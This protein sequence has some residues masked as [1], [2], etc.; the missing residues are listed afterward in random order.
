[1]YRYGR[2]IRFLSSMSMVNKTK[3]DPIVSLELNH[4]TLV[5]LEK[6]SSIDHFRQILGQMMRIGLVGETF[7][8]SRL[9][10]YSAVSHPENLDMAIL[11]FTY[12]TPH[13]NLFIYKTMISAL[14]SSS[15]LAY[16]VYKSMLWS[17]IWPEKQ[18]LLYL[19]KAAKHISEAKQ[20]HCHA[21]V[22]GL[23]SYDYF[24]NSLLKM[25]VKNGKMDLALKVFLC[26]PNS[27]VASFNIM[28]DDRAKKGKSLE[29]LKMYHEM[30]G[31]GLEPDEFTILD[32]L[33]CCGQ[34]ADVRLGK[35]V[36]AWME[37]RK[38]ISPSN[39]VLGNALLH[40]YVKCKEI[41]LAR[42]TFDALRVKDIVSWNTMLEGFAN[43]GELESARNL[44]NLMPYRDIVSWNS[45][46]CSYAQNDDLM[47]M[48]KLFKDMVAENVMPD[49]VT[50][51]IVVTV[52][53]EVGA[54]D[55]G[56]WIHGMVVR[57][58]MKINAILGSALIN[59]YWKCGNVERAFMVFRELTEKDVIVWTT[60]ITGFA[61]HGYGRKAL[62]LFSEM[63]EEVMPNKVT[64]LAVL[65]ACVHCGLVDE[66]L[67]IFSSMKGNYG[68][69]PGIEH[70]G[71][72]VDLLG[73]SGRLT[74]AKDV[75]A[76]MPMKPSPSI[77]GAILSAC[78]A[79]GNVEMAEIAW[80]ELLKLEPEKEGGYVLLSNIYAASKKWSFSDRIRE[81]MESRGVK[82]T[83]G[84]SSIAVDAV[85]HDF[86]ATD[87]RHPRWLDMQS[88]L[89]F[90][91][92]EMRLHTD[93]PQDF[94]LPFMA[95]S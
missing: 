83:A 87:K 84:C 69:E 58:G 68:I 75:I 12:F 27:D 74:E 63:Q 43:V 90:L 22:M 10:L 59:L 38:H 93:F 81:V 9:I 95:T 32:L 76:K 49:Y 88:I 79:Q 13:P 67:E 21:I 54:L 33:I 5:L 39:F 42:R 26:R 57:M 25:Y 86:I 34:L 80:R 14:S 55:Q 60:M 71:C 73:R 1:M 51:T 35:S 36:H 52:A 37:R 30:V 62:E 50:M 66:G 20:I 29:A 18:I 92:S 8:M 78:R 19:L 23:V 44:F 70:Y 89:Y 47:M 77:C 15:R 11:L 40:M 82:K 91:N 48:T 16:V 31:L 46:I 85:L 17:S 65:T 28:I 56:R 72:L 61:F 53:A 3:W 4:Q 94:W 45:L 24:Q 2:G 6:C 64:I 41:E 7:P